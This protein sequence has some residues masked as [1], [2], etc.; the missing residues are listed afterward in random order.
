MWTNRSGLSAAQ[1]R[2]NAGTVTDVQ[3]VVAEIRVD[4]LQAPLVP[5]GVSGRAEEIRARVVID[6]MHLPARL[7]EIIHHL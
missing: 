6:A 1:E 3:F 5:S 7:A 4:G 2:V